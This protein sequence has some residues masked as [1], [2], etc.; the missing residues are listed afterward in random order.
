MQMLHK[1]FGNNIISQNM[2]PPQSPD[3]TPLDF[4]LWGFERKCAQKQPTHVERAKTKNSTVYLKQ[5]V[6]VT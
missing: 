1:F 6:A 3:P 4:C 2:W 5:W